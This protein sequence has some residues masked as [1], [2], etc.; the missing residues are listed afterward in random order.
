MINFTQLRLQQMSLGFS[1]C[2]WSRRRRR[3]HSRCRR[4]RRRHRRRRMANNDINMKCA[5]CVSGV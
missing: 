2:R 5:Q 4:H 3:R 1:K